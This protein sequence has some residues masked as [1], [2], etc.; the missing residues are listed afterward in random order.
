MGMGDGVCHRKPIPVRGCISVARAVNRGG[1]WHGVRGAG[2]RSA[3]L[4]SRGGTRAQTHA[5]G[6]RAVCACLRGQ[7]A[8]CEGVG[9]WVIESLIIKTFDKSY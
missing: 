5:V 8:I 6:V 3:G 7:R 4:G 2:R 1:G 9:H